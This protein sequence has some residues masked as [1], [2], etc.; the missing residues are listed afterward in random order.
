M[1][2]HIT[3]TIFFSGLPLMIVIE[4][5]LNFSP[6][7]ISLN[8]PANFFTSRNG[9]KKLN[10][11]HLLSLHWP[12][13]P[14]Q[15]G[16]Q[17]IFLVERISPLIRIVQT[18]QSILISI[19]RSYIFFSGNSQNKAYSICKIYIKILSTV[20]LHN[21]TIANYYLAILLLLSISSLKI[22]SWQRYTK[23]WNIHKKVR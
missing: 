15:S 2:T 13:K 19:H 11:R 21:R 14:V 7:L 5:Y 1:I 6:F 9:W 8:L 10:Y 16:T 20:H 18:D 23:I 4:S 17:N 22:T 12:T 3:V